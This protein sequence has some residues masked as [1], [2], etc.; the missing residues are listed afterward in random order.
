M[1]QSA[2]FYL[3]EEFEKGP[4]SK[5]RTQ[6]II[7]YVTNVTEAPNLQIYRHLRRQSPPLR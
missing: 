7:F 5:I 4:P 2:L 6:R 3:V 1:I